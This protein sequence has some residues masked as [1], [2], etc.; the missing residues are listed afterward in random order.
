M[1]RVKE[2]NINSCDIRTQ[3]WVCQLDARSVFRYFSWVLCHDQYATQPGIPGQNVN[4]PKCDVSFLDI[5]F[6]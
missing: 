2:T 5:R 1:V 4:Q 3:V 6:G